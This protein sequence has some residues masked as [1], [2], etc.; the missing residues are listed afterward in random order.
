MS[1]NLNQ[2]K[3][4]FQNKLKTYSLTVPDDW[5]LQCAEFVVQ[6]FPVTNNYLYLD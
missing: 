4:A 1:L 2:I 6:E 3:A 5:V